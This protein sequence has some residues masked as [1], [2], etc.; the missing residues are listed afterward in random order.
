MAYL[1]TNGQPSCD[2]LFRG[3]GAI[4][5]AEQGGDGVEVYLDVVVI[6][7]F[8]VD[9]LLILGT[10]RL[11]GFAFGFRRSALAAFLGAIY[12]GACMLPGLYFL[13]N[14]FWRI[15]SLAIMS[16]VA[17]GWGNSALRRGVLFVFLSMALGGIALG[18]GDGSVMGLVM[19]ALGIAVTCVVGFRGRVGQEKYVPVQ[20]A[21][22][23]HRLHF[24]ALLDTGNTLHDPISGRAVLV[25][26]E[27]IGEK[28]FGFS[29]FELEHPVETMEKYGNSGLRLVP[30]H[31]VGR[32]TGMMLGVRV[33]KLKIGGKQQDMIVAIAPQKIGNGDQY[34]ALAGGNVL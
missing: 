16:L 23:N 8:L 6:L 10:N 2:R 17:F 32:P 21:Y 9:F 4:L 12:V 29:R 5:N 20:I 24:L 18:M 34:Q 28:M 25:V 1:E 13:G 11:S 7:N 15:M 27:R 3:F 22:G 26:D 30:Y 19:G 33:D 14:V 31:A